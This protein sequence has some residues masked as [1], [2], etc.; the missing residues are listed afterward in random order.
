MLIAVAVCA[1]LYGR[2]RSLAFSS[3]SVRSCSDVT[4]QRST[5]R[6]SDS[7]PR[8]LRLKT[9]D[10]ENLLAW[11][12]PPAAGRPLI[13][14]FHGN[15]G[16][17]DL[18]VERFH[19]IAKA[20]MGLLA[21][22]YRGYASSTGSPKRARAQARWRSGL[23][24][25]DRE[26]RRARAHRPSRGVAWVRGRGRTRRAPEGWRARTGLAL[27]LNRRRRRGCILVRPGSR[28]APRSVPQR[29][30]DRL[31]QC[32]DADDSRDQG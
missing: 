13:L 24:G 1:A 8:P 15:A 30:A 5:R 29:P 27:F 10:G 17:I 23:C 20:G 12:I 3:A 21:I 9:E 25:G 11:S 26:R 32:A 2:R 16:G 28:I 19:A 4:P 7:R 14:Y 6:R 22:E 31:G 18:R